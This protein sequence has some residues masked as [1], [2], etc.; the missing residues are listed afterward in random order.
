MTVR[1]RRAGRLGCV[2]DDDGARPRVGQLGR[3][4][5]PKKKDKSLTLSR[6]QQDAHG[7]G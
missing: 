1:E 7:E 6:R 4:L 5:V 3:W 2:N